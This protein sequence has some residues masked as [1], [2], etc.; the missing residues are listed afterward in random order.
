VAKK[1]PLTAFIDHVRLLRF[2]KIKVKVEV[3]VLSEQENILA[4]IQQYS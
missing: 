2:F 3:E 1:Y 4:T